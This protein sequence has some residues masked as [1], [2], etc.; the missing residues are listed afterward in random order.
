MTIE[1]RVALYKQKFHDC[2]AIDPV[3][4]IVVME[5]FYEVPELERLE[6]KKAQY[7][8]DSLVYGI[9]SCYHCMG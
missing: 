6:L 2:R 9:Y 3:R 4:N 1:E 5:R 7:R 8:A